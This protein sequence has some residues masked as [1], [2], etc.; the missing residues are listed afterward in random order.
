SSLTGSARSV[1]TRSSTMQRREPDHRRRTHEHRNSDDSVPPSYQRAERSVV[2]ELSASVASETQMHF[3]VRPVSRGNA[4]IRMH[5]R[6]ARFSGVRSLAQAKVAPRAG[7]RSSAPK[8]A[9][10]V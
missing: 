8:N 1:L 9:T 6:L 7:P 3:E 10:S 2:D 5:L 4:S